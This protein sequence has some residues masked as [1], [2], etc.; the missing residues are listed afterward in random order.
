MVHVVSCVKIVSINFSNLG[1]VR[2]ISAKEE[3]PYRVFFVSTRCG[4]PVY[5]F[6]VLHGGWN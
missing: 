5:I 2:V 6:I 3:K 1:E 4:S